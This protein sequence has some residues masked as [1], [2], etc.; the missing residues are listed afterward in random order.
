MNVFLMNRFY[1]KVA[2]RTRDMNKLNDQPTL[3]WN[4]RVN[5]VD[6]NHFPMSS[7]VSEWASE[8]TNERRGA[9]E[10]SEQCVANEWVSS[11]SERASGRAK[12]TIVLA[13]I[14]VHFNP[15]GSWAAEKRDMETIKRNEDLFRE[16]NRSDIVTLS[17]FHPPEAESTRILIPFS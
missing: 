7:G 14:L 6:K 1:W 2:R 3:V 11:V 15:A 12:S 17:A 10:R 8:R 4:R 9:R 13:S 5:F 16:T